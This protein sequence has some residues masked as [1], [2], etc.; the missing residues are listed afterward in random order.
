MWILLAAVLAAMP[1]SDADIDAAIAHGLSRKK[2]ESASCRAGSAFMDFSQYNGGFTVT[3]QGPL[4]RIASAARE[5]KSKYQPFTRAD[6]TDAM[7]APD[8][9]IVAYPDR[10]SATKYGWHY[11]PAATHLVIRSRKDGPVLQPTRVTPLPVEWGNALGGVAHG[12]GVTAVFAMADVQG[13]RGDIEIVVVFEGG[14]R[15][16]TIGANERQRLD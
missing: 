11:T 15:R 1:L 7:R 16:C 6:V 10:P 2:L 9:T 12:Y 14:E 5:A 8:L 4:G 3:A 13:L